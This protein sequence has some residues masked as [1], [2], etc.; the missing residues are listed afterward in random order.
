MIKRL[1]DPDPEVRMPYGKAPLT[2][3]QIAVLKKWIKQRSTLGKTLV[4]QPP[5]K[6][7]AT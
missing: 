7:H 5:K 2:A 1:T 3:K 4:I 6:S